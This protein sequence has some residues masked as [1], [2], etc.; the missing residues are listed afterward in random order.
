MRNE[1]KAE[2]EFAKAQTDARLDFI[3]RTYE[4][5]AT[6]EELEKRVKELE[7]KEQ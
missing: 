2:E 4:L 3:K 1:H 5:F 6:V 7:Q